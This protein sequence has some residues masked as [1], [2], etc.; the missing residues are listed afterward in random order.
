MFFFCYLRQ[1][2]TSKTVRHHNDEVLEDNK[3]DLGHF[4]RHDSDRPRRR[5]DYVV[6]HEK[7]N[8]RET[9]STAYQAH[10]GST[11][12]QGGQLLY[13]SIQGLHLKGIYLLILCINKTV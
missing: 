13:F 7:E 12:G 10:H 11:E 2:R 6:G 1:N 3:F 8:M 9:H 5:R 4:G